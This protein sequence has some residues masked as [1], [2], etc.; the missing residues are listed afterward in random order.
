MAEVMLPLHE[1]QVVELA[2][3]LS[4]EGK[5]AVLRTL[6][7]DLDQ[8]E[9]LVDYGNVRIRA[10]CGQRGINWDSL[11]EAERERLIDDLLHEE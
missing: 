11:S 3:Q 8:F 1:S 10:L 4:P 6:I 5:R 2:R 9:V 7:P